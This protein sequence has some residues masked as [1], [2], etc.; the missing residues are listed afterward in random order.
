VA[1]FGLGP[2]SCPG[3]NLALTQACLTV[4]TL[5]QRVRSTP[6]RSGVAAP[7]PSITLRPAGPVPLQLVGG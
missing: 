7:V 2:R 4:A 3:S 5:A 1:P 6:T